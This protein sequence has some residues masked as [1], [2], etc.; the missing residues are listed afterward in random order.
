MSS[1]FWLIALALNSPLAIGIVMSV[2]LQELFRF[3]I[4]ML[5][6]KA[7]AGLKKLTETD[8][9]VITNKN[10]LAYGMKI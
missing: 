7:E 3:L 5:L 8:H 10:I 9:P 4:Y 1:L 2:V 6:R